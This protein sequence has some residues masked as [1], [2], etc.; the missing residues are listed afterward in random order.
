VPLSHSRLLSLTISS[1]NL[2]A[3]DS[4]LYHTSTILNARV[5]LTLT[6]TLATSHLHLR[7]L[8]DP[9]SRTLGRTLDAFLLA[10]DL[11][12]RLWLGGLGLNELIVLSIINIDFGLDGGSAAA[13]TLDHLFLSL[14][15]DFRASILGV[16]AL[17]GRS[18]TLGGCASGERLLITFSLTTL[19]ILGL[20]GSASLGLSRRIVLLGSR[21]SFGFDGRGGC[22]AIGGTG[23]AVV[24]GE[25]GELFLDAGDG[26]RGGFVVGVAD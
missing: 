11:G 22:R 24:F 26:V 4:N 19:T 10:L 18:G 14:G 23:E 17:L 13:S 16:R 20:D 7:F 6:F 5:M 8:S 15:F 2:L 3:S 9:L 21:S 1:S 12:S 25:F